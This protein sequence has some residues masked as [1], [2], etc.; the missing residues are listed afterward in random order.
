MALI[1]DI[2]YSM[3]SSV[4]IDMPMKLLPTGSLLSCQAPWVLTSQHH[5]F[6]HCLPS[7]KKIT[8]MSL[9]GHERNGLHARRTT[10]AYQMVGRLVN[11]EGASW[12]R[13]LTLVCSMLRTKTAWPLMAFASR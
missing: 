4:V 11:E 8:P 2:N 12:Q 10:M 1:Y 3:T 9:T 6:L 7:E 13:E 5:I